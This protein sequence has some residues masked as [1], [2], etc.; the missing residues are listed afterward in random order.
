[1]R[2]GRNPAAIL[3]ALGDPVRRLIYER[4]T[5]YEINV[6]Q[7]AKAL[8]VT[9]SAVSR[10]LQV[11]KNAGLVTAEASGSNRIYRPCPDGLD[12]LVDWIEKKRTTGAFRRSSAAAGP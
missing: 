10:H 9:R 7:L 5:R 4:L 12:P 8:P 1:M 6:T 3:D 11:L 2:S